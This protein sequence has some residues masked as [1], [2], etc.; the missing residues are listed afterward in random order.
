MP[1]RPALYA[2]VLLIIAAGS[3]HGWN[4]LGHKA[5]AEIAW[6]QLDEPTRQAIVD[7]LRRHPRFDTDFQGKMEDS[8]AKGDKAVQDHWIF[9][10]AATWPDEI[11]KNKE[12]DRP[13]W[14]YINLPIAGVRPRQDT[15]CWFRHRRKMSR[16]FCCRWCCGR[17]VIGMLTNLGFAVRQ[18]RT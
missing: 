3:A 1:L 17:E 8:A 12:Y 2:A 11:R 15:I 13:E 6:Q 4:A 18:Q 16:D 9:Q 7:I 5:V 10:S 14:H